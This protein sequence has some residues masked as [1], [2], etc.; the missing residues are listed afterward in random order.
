MEHFL[1]LNDLQI[2]FILI[3]SAFIIDIIIGDP[4]YPFHPIRILGNW[5]SI[6]QKI[7]FKINLN[8]YLGGF[9]LWIGTLIFPIS[10]YVILKYLISNRLILSIIDLFIFYSFFSA[11]D[12]IKHVANVY[13]SLLNNGIEGGRQSVSLIV[14]RNTDRLSESEVSKAAVETLAE[15]SSDGI[16]APLF[17][18]ILFGPIG[19]I[20]YKAVNTL[21]SMV[22]YK[23]EKY[24]KFGFISAK[25]DDL[26]NFLPS[27]I[28]AI[29]ILF[30]HVFNFKIVSSFWKYR[31]A[32]LSP[33]AGYPE[34]ALAAIM[35]VKMG[36][37]SQYHGKIIDKKYI[38]ENGNHMASK[39]ITL[40]IKIIKLRCYIILIFL[41]LLT[42]I[43]LRWNA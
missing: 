19:V 26:F 14:G 20:V 36:G 18:A 22:G 7:L 12:L 34:S 25:M 42:A 27:R 43:T 32:H 28:T 30:Q 3:T 35:N 10:I 6:L 8:G 37:P 9:F 29:L 17:Y 2:R 31:K 1:Q 21:D 15:N 40:A 16:V 5:I 23:S 13:K 33:N 11:G 4:V 24:L 38:N 39:D 41:L